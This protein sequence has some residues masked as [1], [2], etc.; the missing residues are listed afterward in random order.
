DLSIH[1]SYSRL[2]PMAF[3]SCALTFI[4]QPMRTT[5]MA[6]NS[7]LVFFTKG[8]FLSPKKSRIH[9]IPI[10]QTGQQSNAEYDE[11]NDL[12]PGC[13]RLARFGWKQQQE[14]SADYSDRGECRHF[15]RIATLVKQLMPAVISETS[16]DQD[17]E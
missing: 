8:S 2:R 4:R 13:L 12:I 7:T 9:Q 5:A 15:Q 14:E 16:A 17:E 11:D 1:P 3:S 10:Q 6:T